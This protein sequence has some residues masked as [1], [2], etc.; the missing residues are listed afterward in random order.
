MGPDQYMQ[1]PQYRCRIRNAFCLVVRKARSS[2]LISAA[3]LQTLSKVLRLVARS[4]GQY[5]QSPHRESI[6]YR[7]RQK[8]KKP[9]LGTEL[10]VSLLF[11]VF[12]SFSSVF[13]VF[14]SENQK[15]HGFFW[16]F[17]ALGSQYQKTHCVF[18]FSGFLASQKTKKHSV[19]FSILVLW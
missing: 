14:F 10:L 8:T 16:F 18:W 19:C 12:L 13:L 7:R 6:S 5:A 17:C 9:I 11:L 15:N 4:C 3:Q 2:V 1:N